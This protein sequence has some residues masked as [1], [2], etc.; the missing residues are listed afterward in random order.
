MTSIP[1]G[2]PSATGI[3]ETHAL[4]KRFGNLIAIDDVSLQVWPGEIFGLIGPN[5]AGKSTLIKMLTTLLPPS[6]GTA[7]VA[8]FDVTRHPEKVRAHIGYVPQLLSADRALSAYENLLVSA[9]LYL[10][11]RKEREARIAA[12]LRL[13]DLEDAAQRLVENFSGGMIRRLEIAQSMIHE[14]AVLFMDEPTVGLDPVARHAV[15]DHVRAL[16]ERLGTTILITTHLMDEADELCGRI[17][18]LHMGRLAEVGS[19][20]ELKARIGPDATLEDV[21]THVTGTEM[22]SGGSYRDVRQTRAS[23]RVHS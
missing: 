23:A 6:S 13:M 15:W 19:P 18:V 2:A 7:Q 8:G 3:I 14:P 1:Y 10:V 4:T 20:Q 11:P 12:A 5:G 9:R 16:R 22:T 21:F 17:G